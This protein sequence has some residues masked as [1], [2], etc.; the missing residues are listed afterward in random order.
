MKLTDDQ[1]FELFADDGV[2]DDDGKLIYKLVEEKQSYL[3]LEKGY[4]KMDFVIE[5]L[6]TGKFYQA[7]GL[8]ETYD[9]MPSGSSAK[10]IEV[11]PYTETITKYK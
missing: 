3:D 11:F 6:A 10:W 1:L 8:A 4:R 2:Y 7:K 9:E 5:D